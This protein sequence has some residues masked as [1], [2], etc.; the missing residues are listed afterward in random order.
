M[1]TMFFSYFNSHV[2]VKLRFIIQLKHCFI[3]YMNKDLEQLRDEY[4]HN[5]LS[6]LNSENSDENINFWRESHEDDPAT[7]IQIRKQN[8][9]AIKELFGLVNASPANLRYG[10][11]SSN[12]GISEDF[13]PM[14]DTAGQI[15]QKEREM[16]EMYVINYEIEE[17]N[18]Q[19]YLRSSTG[20][21]QP[22]PKNMNHWYIKCLSNNMECI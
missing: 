18:G 4:E 21:H 15:T 14:G 17:F 10:D 11:G 3:D 22:D 2:I 7:L 5:A 13:D 12:S 19:Y 1:N 9:K 6:L 16:L 20:L 8:A